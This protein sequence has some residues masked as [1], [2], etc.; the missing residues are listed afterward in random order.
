MRVKQVHAIPNN[1]T[2]LHQQMSDHCFE[3]AALP[4]GIY[5]LSIPTGEGKR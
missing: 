2:K 3:K 4:T 5:T 1:I